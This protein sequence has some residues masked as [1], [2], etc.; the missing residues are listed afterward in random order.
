MGREIIFTSKLDDRFGAGGTFDTNNDAD[1]AQPTPGDWGGIYVG[2]LGQASIDHALLTFGGGI[3]KIEGTFKGFNIL[4]IHQADVRLANSVLENNADGTGGQGPD[5]RF[6]RTANM[7]ATIFI[8]GSQPVIVDNVIQNNEGVAITIDTNSLNDETVAD[9]GRTTGRL[10]QPIRYLDNQGP[11]IRGNR[12]ANSVLNGLDLREN[13][14]TAFT[15]W[16]DTDIVHVVDNPI[17]VPDVHTGVGL[18]IESSSNESLV[19]KF[20]GP[21]DN[22]RPFLGAGITATGRLL[23]NENRI[24]GTVHIVGQPDFPVV[25]TSLKDDTIGAGLTPDGR[26]NL[27]TNNDGDATLPAPGDWRSVRFEPYSNDR[28]VE[29]VLENESPDSIAPG[30]NA[31][32]DSAQ[33][34]GDLASRETASDDNLRLGFQVLGE[35]NQPADIDVYSFKAEAGTEVWLDIDRTSPSLNTVVELIDADGN[36]IARSDDSYFETL[37]TSSLYFDPL[38]INADKV[39]P[40]QEVNDAFQIRHRSGQPKDQF[41]QNLLDAGFRVVLPGVVGTRSTYHVR[42]RS[43]SQNLDDLT[44]G[45]TAGAYELHIRTRELDEVPGGTVRYADIRYATNGVELIGVPYHSPLVGEVGE[46]EET[47]GPEHNG[48]IPYNPFV[49]GSGPQDIGNLLETDRGTLSIGGSLSA[50][51]DIDFYEMTVDYSASVNNRFQHASVVLDV[52]YA[53]G[54]SRPDSVLTIYDAF[55]RLIFIGRDSNISDDRSGP[56]DGGDLSDMSRGSVGDRDPY[57][58]PIEL[59]EGTYFVGVSSNDRLPDELTTNPFVRLEPINAIARIAEDGFDGA[60][61]ATVDPPQVTTLFDEASIVSEP[62]D[63]LTW[64][65]SGGNGGELVAVN[66]LTGKV[67]Q[68]VG[69]IQDGPVGDIAV[70][71][72]DGSLHGFRAD[73]GELP[74]D[75]AGNY[76]DINT[77]NGQNALDNMLDDGIITYEEDPNNPGQ[78]IV[79]DVGIQFN[80]LAFGEPDGQLRLFAVGNRGDWQDPPPGPDSFTNIMY[81]LDPM[82][83]EAISDPYPDRVADGVLEGAGTQIVERAVFN[84]ATPAIYPEVEINNPEPPQ[85]LEDLTWSLAYDPWIGDT[86]TNT[87]T[88]I[89]HVTIEGTGDLTADFYEFEVPA[90]GR[91]IIDIDNTSP[92]LDTSITLF[93]GGTFIAS[94]DN[95]PTSFGDGGS[96][97]DRDSFI[98]TVVPAGTYTIMVTSSGVSVLP[99]GASYTLQ[100]SVEGHTGDP[101]TA[102]IYPEVE[103]NNP[104]PPQD[105]EKLLWSYAY[106]PWIGDA[107]TNTSTRIPHITIEGTGDGTID[108]YSFVAS[109]SGKLIIDI[110]NTSPGFDSE[111]VLYRNGAPIAQNDDA[112]IS[113]GSGGS[114]STTDSYLELGVTPGTYTI[115]VRS[116]GPAGVPAGA[117]YTLQVSLE[118]HFADRGPQITGLAFYEDTLYAVTD[119]AQVYRVEDPLGTPSLTLLQ[120]FREDVID[121]EGN[122][123]IPTAR[124]LENELWTLQAD[125][126]IANSTSV[127]HISVIRPDAN[128]TRPDFFSF[129]SPNATANAVFAIDSADYTLYTLRLY[130]SAG[131]VIQTAVGFNPVLSATL[132]EPGKYYVSVEYVDYLDM[133]YR[134]N[135]SVEGH[136]AAFSGL[137]ARDRFLDNGPYTDRL[138]A[139]GTSGRVY[140]LDLDGNLVTDVF[141]GVDRID[142]GVRAANG[143]DFSQ[144]NLWHPTYRRAEDFGHGPTEAPDDS[145]GNMSRVPE[146]EPNNSIAEAHNLENEFWNLGYN[147]NIGQGTTN[148]STTI[149]HVTIDGSG[150]GTV[151]YYLFDV[152]I[153]PD[154][155][156]G[157]VTGIFDVDIT[158]DEQ[159]D[160]TGVFDGELYLFDASSGALLASNIDSSAALG[161]QGSTSDVDPYLEYTFDTNG[162]Y[163]ILVTGPLGTPVQVGDFYTLQVSLEEHRVDG[164]RANGGRSFYFGHERVGNDEGDYDEYERATGSILSYPFSLEGY[165]PADRPTLYFNYYSDLN[166]LE[167]T[168]SVFVEAPGQ[169]PVQ[170]AAKDANILNDPLQPVWRQA[171][172]PLDQFAGMTD[173]RLRLEVTAPDDPDD[174]HPDEQQHGGRKSHG[175]P[176]G[177][178]EAGRQRAQQHRHDAHEKRIGELRAHVLDVIAAGGHRRKDRRVGDR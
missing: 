20:D 22:F 73:P 109:A 134:L 41:S 173:L 15:V 87:S 42:V 149:P 166:I 49:P 144:P 36:V 174:E 34:L 153:P 72:L 164:P 4:E 99:N 3:N 30:E 23:D 18:R 84:T 126:N 1:T 147:S 161:D 141:G 68:R 162:T 91:V 156:D 74:D 61:P 142:T 97:S 47:G 145:R 75:T 2:Y 110:D 133:G 79:S 117:Q 146:I 59:P 152:V 12:L 58:G 143:I 26:A 129:E 128:T 57:I 138:F 131:T 62:V 140:S 66:P 51:V 48:H 86:T 175:K 5:D 63:E 107:T 31:G 155:D 111:I 101:G 27:D 81:Q 33:F 88:T 114:T 8:R 127:P 25:L 104:F 80:A 44:A 71:P 54:L 120:D 98:E 93:R 137:A 154:D 116:S 121:P 89:P 17:I 122:T 169:P 132:P 105:L 14:I 96:T 113:F 157:V 170:V 171:R 13:V 77:S 136:D 56:L 29:V 85:N 168:V 7:P 70:R 52:D 60:P 115:E 172:V 112:P 67:E 40:L 102:G 108:N 106:D 100:V 125:P 119:A 16:D 38:V 103:P 159:L 167:D 53:D 50:R 176:P 94:N 160:P 165:S 124:S 82:T 139:L 148:T 65:I 130:D 95:S 45:S 78:P 46:D 10:E 83:G 21:A 9:L 177:P 24:G 55:G 64:F 151:D 76:L 158:F 11:V 35:I 43:S 32:P 123:S 28:N 163:A 90:T 135:I 39:R 6:G 178:A 37:G 92:G 19:V 150:D 69:A 118:D